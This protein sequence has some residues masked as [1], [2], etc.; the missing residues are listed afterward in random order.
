MDRD[1]QVKHDDMIAVKLDAERRREID[2]VRR[3]FEEHWREQVQF[4]ADMK[5]KMDIVSEQ[6]KGL[7]ERFEEGVSKR[8]VR[9]DDKIDK[10]IFELGQKKKDDEH[11]DEKIAENKTDIREVDSK[12]DG[13][14][15]L[16]NRVTI[17]I[18]GGLSLALILW[19]IKTFG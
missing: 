2:D 10:I 9:V 13:N 5:N 6:Q 4:Q 12:A 17:S 19:A 3:N 11:R 14:T 15:R 16:W 18:A 7:K 8:L 1:K